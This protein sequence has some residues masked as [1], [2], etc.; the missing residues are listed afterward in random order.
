M[1]FT[2]EHLRIR[3]KMNFQQNAILHYVRYSTAVD[4]LSSNDT[5]GISQFPPAPRNIIPRCLPRPSA[6]KLIRIKNSLNAIRNCHRP[7]YVQIPR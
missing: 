2:S 7:D 4:V 3:A 5:L 1:P 6:C